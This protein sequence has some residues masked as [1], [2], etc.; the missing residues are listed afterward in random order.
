MR[1]I[2][3]R[4]VGRHVAWAAVAGIV[5]SIV[6]GFPMM[7]MG[8]LENMVAALV[9]SDSLLVGWMVHLAAGAVFGGALGLFVWTRSLLKGIAFGFV[10]GIVVGVLFAWL[11][12]FT[13]LGLPISLAMPE[14]QNDLAL[15]LLWGIVLGAVYAFALRATEP[16]LTGERRARRMARR[17]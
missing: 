12:V 16:E 6:I 11:A 4:P 5:A 10:W 2:G 9:G 13:L 14:A 17:T 1:D 3:W 7:A 15:H 8:A